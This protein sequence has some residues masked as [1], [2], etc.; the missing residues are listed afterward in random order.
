MKTTSPYGRSSWVALFMFI[1]NLFSGF[2]PSNV[3]KETQTKSQTL[4]DK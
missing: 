2:K 4:A 3:V 1:V